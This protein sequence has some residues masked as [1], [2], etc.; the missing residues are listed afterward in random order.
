MSS[1]LLGRRMAIVVVCVLGSV[2]SLMAAPTIGP[3]AITPPEVLVNS[4][5]VVTVT[6]SIQDP[7]VIPASVNLQRLN[8]D[9][10]VVGIVGSLNDSGLNGDA[11]AGDGVFT[12]EWIVQPMAAGILRFQVSAG[13]RGLLRRVSSTP[14][15]LAVLGEDFR[16]P[17][18]SADGRYVVYVASS[19]LV[20]DDTN[21]VDDIYLR[22]RVTGTVVRVSVSSDGQQGNG[23]SERPGI[24]AS[25]R[26]V[27]FA[28]DASTLV[29]GDTNG[30]RDVFWHDRDAD[31]NGVFDEEWAGA[32]TTERVSVA[33]S[34]AQGNARSGEPDL[35]PDGLWVVFT[36]SASTFV[37]A[38]TNGVSDVFLRSVTGGAT[39]RVSVAVDGTQADGRSWEPSVSLGAQFVVFVSVATN[40]VAGDTNGVAD[41]FRWERATGQ[42]VRLSP[43]L[44]P[45]TITQVAPASGPMAGGT[46]L[47]ITGS[48]FG[49]GV[50]VTVGGVAATLVVVLDST[51]ITAVTPAGTVGSKAV[52]VT[53][54]G[55]TATLPGAF[56]YASGPAPDVIG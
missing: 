43:P 3:V 16:Q 18:L 41:V 49:A 10:K 45:P 34:G 39:T 14:V 27:A 44:P 28:S 42:I 31:G 55:G 4:L 19:A 9:G 11:V 23:S 22:D 24:S 40:L 21:G 20:A 35:S 56:T 46:R 8:D 36:S 12:I 25:G 17:A 2:S 50:V 47:T 54:G 7:G 15:A 1:A 13:F 30:A 33:T 52:T 48:G 32:T 38:D 6:A 5:S 29:S 26:Y 37:P 51:I 53:T